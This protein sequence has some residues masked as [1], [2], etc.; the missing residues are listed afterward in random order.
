MTGYREAQSRR[1]DAV[2]STDSKNVEVLFTPKHAVIR[3]FVDYAENKF[4]DA[5]ES[6][7]SAATMVYEGKARRL[8]LFMAQQKEKRCVEVSGRSRKTT[9]V[10]RRRSSEN[11]SDTITDY[12][13]DV[14][15]HPI[16][17]IDTAFEYISKKEKTTLSLFR[18]LCS[19]E[20]DIEFKLFCEHLAEMQAEDIGLL[21][22]EYG[23]IVSEDQSA[24]TM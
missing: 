15:L 14:D 9:R 10:R 1:E 6:Y 16:D 3:D 22:E 24:L 18:R 2:V 5:G 17:T 12:L 4:R 7:A 13:I 20:H 8:L 23:R 21:E 19:R 11:G